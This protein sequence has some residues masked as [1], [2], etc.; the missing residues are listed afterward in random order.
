LTPQEFEKEFQNRLGIYE[1]VRSAVF[2]VIETQLNSI[3]VQRLPLQ[4]RIK[5]GESAKRKQV[6]KKYSEP[7]KNMTDLL[8]FRVVV[9]VAEDVDAVEHVIRNCFE[10]DEANSVDK[11]VPVEVG[12]VG[13]RS[14]HLV[15]SLGKDRNK[16][17]EY[18]SVC[19]IPFEIQ[20][21]T[22]LEHT[23]AEIEHQKNYKSKVALPSELQRRLFVLAGTLELVDR[24]LSSISQD[25]RRYAALAASSDESIEADLVSATSLVAILQSALARRDTTKTISNTGDGDYSNLIGELSAFDIKRNQ[26]LSELIE[27]N[28]DKALEKNEKEL[29]VHG[30]VRDT[31]FFANPEKFFE[32]TYSG[33]YVFEHWDLDILSKISGVDALELAIRYG[34]EIE[35]SQ[36]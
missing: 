4:A 1:N 32:K 35:Y 36:E 3:K 10:V 2:G 31:M 23:W 30:L 16:L 34:A 15:C 11:R 19:N 33:Q 8:A 25:A 29:Y 13:Y 5:A 9:Y 12:R 24:E 6:D 7:F 21:R 18:K 26:A 20:V 17:P 28:L 27:T 14:L 22:I